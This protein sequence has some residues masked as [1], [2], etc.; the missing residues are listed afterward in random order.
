MNKTTYYI[1]GNAVREL[2][3]AAPVRRPQKSTRE[4]EEIRR[5]KTRTGSW[6]ASTSW[7]KKKSLQSR[8]P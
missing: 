6:K 7:Q 1:N 8:K 5:K 2:D 3:E 4:L